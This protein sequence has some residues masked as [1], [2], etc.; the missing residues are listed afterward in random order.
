MTLSSIHELTVLGKKY[1]VLIDGF[2]SEKTIELNELLRVA[3]DF[4]KRYNISLTFVNPMIIASRIHA[5]L[6][7]KYALKAFAN[8]ENIS[9]KL[10]IEVLLYVTGRRQIKDAIK[11][12]SLPSKV[13]DFITIFIAD[14]ESSLNRAYKD[15]I[16]NFRLKENESLWKID[17][18]KFEYLKK[19]FE[20]S[21]E[22]LNA[23][24]AKNKK[25]ALIK[26][27]ISRVTMLYVRK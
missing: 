24:Y 23:T 9:R 18:D 4:S 20:V 26:C 6:A 3:Q 14:N 8:K 11:L 16:I 25:E 12:A 22:E 1:Y 5:L 2:T 13:R 7:T 27:I 19:V 15:F 10:E 21:D 17:S